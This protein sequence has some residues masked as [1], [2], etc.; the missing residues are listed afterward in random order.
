MYAIIQTGSKQY[1]VSEGSVINV[2]KLNYQV[3]EE[4]ELRPLAI[5]ADSGFSLNRGKVIAK[6]LN[7]SKAKKV[8]VFKFRAKKNYKRLKGHR[9][10]LTTIS[11]EKILEE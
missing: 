4:I 5:F 3:G 1:R 2:E 10:E 7:H 8:L 6:V 9:Q 11:I